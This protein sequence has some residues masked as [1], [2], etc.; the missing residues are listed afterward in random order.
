MVKDDL[1]EVTWDERPE[2]GEGRSC[3]RA[4]KSG[5]GRGHSKCKFLRLRQASAF[6]ELHG[7]GDG[8]Q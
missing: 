3:G 2:E 8:I 6:Q 4:G 1:T 5:S 7:Q